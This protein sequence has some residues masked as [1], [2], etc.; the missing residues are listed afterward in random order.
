MLR[1]V[2]IFFFCRHATTLIEFADISYVRFT[3][4]KTTQK[5]NQLQS[6]YWLIC[7]IWLRNLRY[8]TLCY[9]RVIYR[10]ITTVF[11]YGGQWRQRSEANQLGVTVTNEQPWITSMSLLIILCLR[12]AVMCFAQSVTYFRAWSRSCQ[13]R[14]SLRKPKKLGRV[15]LYCSIV[16]RKKRWV[17]GKK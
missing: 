3:W 5:S 10:A 13:Q 8:A 1:T 6:R 16:P 9:T 4:T 11:L 7:F 17:D 15:S 14:Q 2:Y 12:D